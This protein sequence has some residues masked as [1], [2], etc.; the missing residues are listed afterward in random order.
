[1]GRKEVIWRRGKKRGRIGGEKERRR[2]LGEYRGL[3][4]KKFAKQLVNSS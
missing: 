3:P 2:E 4:A 1:M